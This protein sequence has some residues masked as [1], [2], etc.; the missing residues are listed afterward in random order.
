MNGKENNIVKLSV[1]KTIRITPELARISIR[2]VGDGESIYSVF[3]SKN[4]YV[5]SIEYP[6]LPPPCTTISD[7]YAHHIFYLENALFRQKRIQDNC[8]NL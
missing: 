7:L 5:H 2:L 4:Q 8:L 6:D 3:L 1:S